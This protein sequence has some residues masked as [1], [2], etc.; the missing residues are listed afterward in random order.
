VKKRLTTNRVLLASLIG[1]ALG[2]IL[3]LI[4]GVY[5]KV[6]GFG[7]PD[8]LWV[9]EHELQYCPRCGSQRWA[10][11]KGFFF[12]LASGRV[13]GKLSRQFNGIDQTKCDHMFFPIASDDMLLT[14][15]F[16][17]QRHKLGQPDGDAFWEEPVLVEAFRA[18][19]KENSAS[20]VSLFQFVVNEK[21]RGTLSLSVVEAAKGTN[22]QALVDAMNQAYT[23]KFKHIVAY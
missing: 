21:Q 14:R 20:A 23:N 18:M 5:M 16:K 7:I 9:R 12:G 2:G 13:E 22:S 1:A 17:L 10:S 19:E 8:V 3:I 15:D 4:L 6:V 11:T